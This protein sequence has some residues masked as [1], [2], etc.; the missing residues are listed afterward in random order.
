MLRL[1]LSAIGYRLLIITMSIGLRAFLLSS[2][3]SGHLKAHPDGAMVWDGSGQITF[4][5]NW[6]DR[7]SDEQIPWEDKNG[8]LVTP[9]FITVHS[10]LPQYPPIPSPRPQLP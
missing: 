2:S 10:P 9:A 5:G 8:K 4:V 7:P 3:D 1:W 6:N